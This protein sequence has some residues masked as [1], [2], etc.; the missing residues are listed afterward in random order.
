M[1]TTND[2]GTGHFPETLDH[3]EIGQAMTVQRVQAPHLAPEWGSWLEEIGFMAGEH[4]T[5]MARALP[6]GEPMVVRIGQSTFALRRAEAA[7]V[8]VLPAMV[9][10]TAPNL[11]SIVQ[12]AGR[13]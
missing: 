13:A 9:H 11:G 1:K 5:L 6:G 8:R 12:E 10:E 2:S 3:A 7:C 4:V